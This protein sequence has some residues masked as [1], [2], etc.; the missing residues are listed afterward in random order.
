MSADTQKHKSPRRRLGQWL[1][2][3]ERAL[4]SERVGGREVVRMQVVSHYLGAYRQQPGE[5]VD[6]LA[7]GGQGLEV[8]EV[9]DVMG[10]EGVVTAAEAEGVLQLG[11]TRQNRALEA[12][13]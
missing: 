1:P 9:A 4:A 2:E 7:E 8:L 13:R 12:H 10:D 3:E 11:A 5:M 6:A